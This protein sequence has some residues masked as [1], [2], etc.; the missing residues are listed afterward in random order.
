MLAEDH[1]KDGNLAD[2]MASIVQA[3]KAD[4]AKAELRTFLFQLLAVTGDWNRALNQLN[5]AG[6]LDAAALP[7]VKRWAA[8]RSGIRFSRV[9]VRRWCSATRSSGSHWSSSR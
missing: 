3:I 8:R 1:L 7:I 4:P 6:E 9:S 5:V 2:T